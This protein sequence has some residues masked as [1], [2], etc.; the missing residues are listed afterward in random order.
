PGA[1]GRVACCV[2][3]VAWHRAPRTTEDA[4]R[5]AQHAIRNTQHATRN[6]HQL[7]SA[8]P[9]LLLTLVL[10]SVPA[11]KPKSSDEFIRLT[12][13]GKNYYDR[14]EAAKAVTA[15]EAAL[16]LNPAHPDAHLNLASAYLLANQPDK[17]LPHADQALKL[18]P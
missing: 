6:T 11:C 8:I 4:P 7:F 10:L 18:N 16:A 13:T 12:N 17:A 5:H 3:R 14:G 2:L 9:C 15:L 1:N